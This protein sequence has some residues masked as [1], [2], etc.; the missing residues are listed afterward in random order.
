MHRRL[1]VSA[2]RGGRAGKQRRGCYLLGFAYLALLGTGVSWWALAIYYAGPR[3]VELAV[4]LA[5]AYAGGLAW[6]SY[7][8]VGMSRKLA[9]TALGVALP[10]LWWGSITPR[11]DRDW[12]PEVSRLPL[13]EIQG[14]QMTVRNVRQFSYRT[15]SDFTP[16]WVDRTYDL[17]KLV[18]LDIFLSYWGS[19]AIAHTILSWDFESGPPLAISI[20][21]R[22]SR[23]EGYSTLAGFFKQYE[24]IYVAADERDLIRLRTRV[25][26]EN[27]Y[28]YRTR[29]APAG[30]RALLLDYAAEMQRLEREPRFYNA[31]L[32]NCTTTIV[33]HSR[34]IQ[35]APGSLDWRMLLNGYADSLLYERGFLDRRL[36]FGELRRE[37]QI[38]ERARI[39]DD[40]EN[41]SQR[42]REGLP[43]PRTRLL[44]PL[45]QLQ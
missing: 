19:P 38:N 20:E 27:V 4:V 14:E 9:V 16:R 22:K 12:E 25:R 3:P 23:G 32:H 33:M 41:F 13:V 31:L 21:T 5:A 28:L 43:D 44:S 8:C 15:E 42:I 24:L 30:A 40:A 10:L 29:I 2:H 17:S 7:S 45:V 11:N 35:A 34:R 37:S 39:A 36:E 6:I 1:L 26:G 18:G